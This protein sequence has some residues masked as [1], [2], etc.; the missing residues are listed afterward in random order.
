MGPPGHAAGGEVAGEDGV[1]RSE[2]QAVAGDDGDAGPGS[3]RN[4]IT[5][6]GGL[7]GKGEGRLQRQRLSSA[8]TSQRAVLTSKYGLLPAA[9]RVVAPHST[10]AAVHPPELWPGRNVRPR[11]VSWAPPT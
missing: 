6:G 11:A 9:P 2:D 5:G 4:A 7:E 8:H 1:V 10:R 3:S